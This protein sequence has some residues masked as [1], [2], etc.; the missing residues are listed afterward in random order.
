MKTMLHT[1]TDES[2]KGFTLIEVL[3]SLAILSIG[4]LAVASLQVSASLLSRNSLEITE[5]SAIASYQME[6]LMRMPYD[7]S[8]LN[9][10]NPHVLSLSS[11]PPEKFS[12]P[13]NQYSVQWTVTLIKLNSA[14][15]TNAKSIDLTVTRIASPRTVRFVFVKHNDL[16]L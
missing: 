8:D 11:I 4:I 14:S 1:K 7:S 10:T 5:A 9:A 6:A 2:D 12:I 13:P 15:T 3:I 16:L